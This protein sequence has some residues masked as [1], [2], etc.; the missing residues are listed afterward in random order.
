MSVVDLDSRRARRLPVLISNPDNLLSSAADRHMLCQ[1]HEF[2]RA[3]LEVV[4]RNR[5][6]DPKERAK[7]MRMVAVMKAQ[8][9]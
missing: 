7:V 1:L 3:G 4:D 5:P 8:P 9:Q 2:A 6:L